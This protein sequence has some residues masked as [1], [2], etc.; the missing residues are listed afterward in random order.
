MDIDVVIAEKLRHRC[1]SKY[2]DNLKKW[3]RDIDHTRSTN[4]SNNTQTIESEWIKK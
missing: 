4:D 1:R 2:I 3:K